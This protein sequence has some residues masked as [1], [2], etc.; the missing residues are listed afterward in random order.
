MHG[1]AAIVCTI[2]RFLINGMF[3]TQGSML[4]FDGR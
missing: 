2:P 3:N 4:Y 1:I